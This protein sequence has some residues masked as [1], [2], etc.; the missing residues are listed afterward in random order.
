MFC[1]KLVRSEMDLYIQFG[2][3]HFKKRIGESSEE[4]QEIIQS[5]KA[6]TH[7]KKPSELPMFILRLRKI[8]RR[9]NCL[10]I[11]KETF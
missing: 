8:E 5:L 1:S 4:S 7:E 2:E 9:Y 10:Q 3:P 11:H 6:M